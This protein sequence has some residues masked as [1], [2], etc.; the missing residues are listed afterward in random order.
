[1]VI[2]A[3]ELHEQMYKHVESTYRLLTQHRNQQISN[4]EQRYEENVSVD[5]G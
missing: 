1:M 5:T 4:Y 2:Y 3:T